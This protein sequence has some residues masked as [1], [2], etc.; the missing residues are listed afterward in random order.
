MSS[1]VGDL[2]DS[3]PQLPAGQHLPGGLRVHDLVGVQLHLRGWSQ[4]ASALHPQPQAHQRRGGEEV[5]SA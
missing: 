3:Q 1:R 4:A 2:P 5:Q